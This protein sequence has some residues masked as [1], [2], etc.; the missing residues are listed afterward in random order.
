MQGLNSYYKDLVVGNVLKCLEIVEIKK[1][2]FKNYMRSVG[3]LG[4]Q[5]KPAR[6]ANDRKIADKLKDFRVFEN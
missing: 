1:G 4:G 5:N 2:G 3:K 6:L